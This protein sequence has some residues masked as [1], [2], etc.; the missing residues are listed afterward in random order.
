MQY[1]IDI[2]DDLTNLDDLAAT[3]AAIDEVMEPAWE[4]RKRIETLVFAQNQADAAHQMM[5][6]VLGRK[7]YAQWRQPLG[8]YPYRAGATVTHNGHK[9]SNLHEINVW[10]PG[11]HGWDDEGLADDPD[12]IDPDEYEAWSPDSVAYTIG[13]HRT[14]NGNVYVCTLAHTSQPGWAPGNAAAL[15]ETVSE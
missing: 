6:D 8:A 4:A 13:Q 10:E 12:P 15:W 7:P 11:V 3:L 9:W 5:D 14:H 2:P 1:V